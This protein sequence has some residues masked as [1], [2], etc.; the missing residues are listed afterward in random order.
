MTRPPRRRGRG[1]TLV[2]ILVALLVLGVVGGALLEL[3]HGALRNIAV[4]ADYTRA[5]LLARSMLAQLE[6]RESFVAAEEEGR[7]DERFY[8]RLRATDY[9]EPDGSPLPKASVRPVLVAFSVTWNDGD[10]ERHYAV[11]SLFLSRAR[12]ERQ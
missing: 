2:E 7:F 9:V 3:F 8:W 5:A 12:E 4:S 11:T 1:F 6:A 10:A